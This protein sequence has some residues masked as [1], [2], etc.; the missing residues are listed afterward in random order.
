MIIIDNIKENFCRQPRNGIQITTW[1]DDPYD[2]ELIYLQR[3]LLNMAGQHPGDL[4][5]NLDRLKDH[6]LLPQHF[7]EPIYDDSSSSF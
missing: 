7:A 4:R 1:K 3:L 6:G 5:V 2:T